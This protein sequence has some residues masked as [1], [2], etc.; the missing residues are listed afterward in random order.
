MRSVVIMDPDTG[1]TTTVN[2]PVYEYEP[3]LSKPITAFSYDA[4]TDPTAE[5]RL[6]K[7]KLKQYKVNFFANALKKTLGKVRSA[8][9]T[10]R[11]SASARAQRMIDSIRMNS[12]SVFYQDLQMPVFTRLFKRICSK[13]YKKDVTGLQQMHDLVSVV[14]STHIGFTQREEPKYK[15]AMASL[16]LVGAGLMDARAPEGDE[17]DYHLLE[18]PVKQLTGESLSELTADEYNQVLQQ[19][20]Q[21]QKRRRMGRIG[22]KHIRR[23]EKIMI[24]VLEAKTA[25]KEA[26]L[27][28]LQQGR[29]QDYQDA[30][31][32]AKQTLINLVKQQ[33][34][35]KLPEDLDNKLEAMLDNMAP[36]SVPGSGLFDDSTHESIPPAIRQTV[37]TND[38]F[39]QLTKQQ[40]AE[41]DRLQW[42]EQG[43]QTMQQTL[44]TL[45]VQI[46]AK[47]AV[48][49]QP[50]V[51]NQDA[52]EAE[53]AELKEQQVRL[54]EELEN[55]SSDL[56]KKEAKID[57][58]EAQ[59]Q[60]LIAIESQQEERYSTTKT[61]VD[62][63]LSETS[64]LTGETCDLITQAIMAHSGIVVP[65]P[66]SS[67]VSN[68]PTTLRSKLEAYNTVSKLRIASHQQEIAKA[69][70][71]EIADYV[72]S[73]NFPTAEGV[74]ELL[75]NT[76]PVSAT[77]PAR[78]KF[79]EKT[80]PHFLHA[81]DCKKQLVQAFR[82]EELAAHPN[83]AGRSDSTT[84]THE[85]VNN[86]VRDI[87][88]KSGR[89]ISDKK[90][91]KY[92]EPLVT[93]LSM[94]VVV[95]NRIAKLKK[96]QS[97]EDTNSELISISKEIDAKQVADARRMAHE[98]VNAMNRSDV[99]I[100]ELAKVVY[101]KSRSM[102]A[103]ITNELGPHWVS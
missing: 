71:R 102:R 82:Q 19:A 63:I 75:T 48:L 13:K 4:N 57:E 18:P 40:N 39:I 72:N 67:E 68:D 103:R 24:K 49:S 3:D 81:S 26:N 78:E 51:D 92:N 99:T 62:R 31:E 69:K 90:H 91:K 30:D 9:H 41:Q 20:Q 36:W 6:I 27:L 44:D 14:L 88:K 61:T 34:S 23:I 37:P 66:I 93:V 16:L 80:P 73:G 70:A 38:E 50:A 79:T 54:W 46:E 10:L 52:Q 29:T 43:L 84:V 100:N 64:V 101:P 87:L 59:K 45:D 12:K 86:D 33:A 76:P 32:V 97:D 7:K 53:L 83:R 89:L 42:I 65:G 25:A 28:A 85:A 74:Y 21:K 95:A 96:P 22:P 35:A 56:Q 1:E 94:H 98:L 17:F 55:A 60:E 77:E 8:W 11:L 15:D 47:E 5:P 2:R 58:L